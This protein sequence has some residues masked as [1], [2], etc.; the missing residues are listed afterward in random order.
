MK[1]LSLNEIFDKTWEIIEE[2]IK[3]GSS[4]FHVG[5][6]ATVNQKGNP[7]ARSVVIRNNDKDKKNISFNT[8]IRS[9]KWNELKL[10]PKLSFTFYDFKRKLQIRISGKAKLHNKNKIADS[11]WGAMEEMSKICY[12]SPLTPSTL[13]TSP[14]QTDSFLKSFNL[15]LLKSGKN[16]FGR[17]VVDIKEIDWLFLIH[18]GHR[19]ARFTIKKDKVGMNWIA[20]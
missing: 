7:A 14:E 3:D 12:A 19:R 4:P 16:N 10:K 8:D 20:P 9:N 15:K 5:I 6:V 17:I 13:I 2:G 18:T 1:N 11:A